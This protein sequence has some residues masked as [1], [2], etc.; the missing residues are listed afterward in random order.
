M[1]DTITVA[2][3]STKDEYG[4]RTW[5]SPTSITQCRV[6]SGNHKVVDTVGQEKVAVGRV[7]VPGSPTITLNDKVTLPDGST[8]PLLAVDSYKDERGSHHTVIHYGGG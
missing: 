6:Q 5:G 7:Y 1:I 4:K 8:P 2:A 3:V